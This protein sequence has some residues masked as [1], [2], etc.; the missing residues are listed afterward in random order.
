MTENSEVTAQSRQLSAK[1][2]RGGGRPFSKGR[3]GN[4][5]GRPKAEGEIRSLAQKHGPAAF[6]RLLELMR[7]E[8]E[9]VAVAAAQAVL[10]RGYGKPAQAV[11]VDG[12]IGPIQ[13]LW[14]V[15]RSPLDE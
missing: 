6:A 5:G 2:R 9:R 12:E 13:L 10:D 15:A 8:N 7:S 11:H 3:S 1:A 14:P 4:P